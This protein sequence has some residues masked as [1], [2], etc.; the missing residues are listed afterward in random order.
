M[1]MYFGVSYLVLHTLL[2]Q[3]VFSN[4]SVVFF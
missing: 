2:N 3:I 4:F 1:L